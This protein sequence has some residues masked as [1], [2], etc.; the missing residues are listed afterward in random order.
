MCTM[1]ENQNKFCP[2]K[3]HVVTSTYQKWGADA[4]GDVHAPRQRQR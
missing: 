1:C 3:Q 4:G 2:K